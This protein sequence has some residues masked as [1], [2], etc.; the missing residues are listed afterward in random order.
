MASSGK[1]PTRENAL[2]SQPVAMEIEGSESQGSGSQTAAATAPMQIDEVATSPQP[3][4]HP[5]WMVATSVGMSAVSGHLGG[6]APS[7]QTAKVHAA[8]ASQHP[9]RA[10]KAAGR[11]T[12]AGEHGDEFAE[13]TASKYAKIKSTSFGVARATQYVAGRPVVVPATTIFFKLYL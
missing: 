6:Q 11:T 5:E 3:A 2:S 1:Q 9:A 4:H 7:A 10:V 8:W 12:P 13:L